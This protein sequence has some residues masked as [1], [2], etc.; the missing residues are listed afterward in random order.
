[1]F[2][3]GQDG[4]LTAASLGDVILPVTQTPTGPFVDPERRLVY[5]FDTTVPFFIAAMFD[6]M[7]TAARR[8]WAVNP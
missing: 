1:L 4:R 3:L 8:I 7:E 2:D 6:G 5:L